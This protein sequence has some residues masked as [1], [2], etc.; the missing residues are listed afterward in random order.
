MK[1][2]R[3]ANAEKA[4]KTEK[5]AKAEKQEPVAGPIGSAKPDKPR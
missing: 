3:T 4:A 1:P 5:P 2:P